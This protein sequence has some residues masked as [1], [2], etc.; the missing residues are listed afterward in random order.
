VLLNILVVL[1][2]RMTTLQ[3]ILMICFYLVVLVAIAYFTRAT[4]RR[5]AGAF[6]SAAAVGLLVLGMV[7]IGEAM[8]LWDVTLSRTP[9]LV[10]MLYLALTVSCAPIYLLSWRIARRFGWAGLAI[11]VGVATIVGPLRDYIVAANHPQWIEFAPGGAPMIA[12]GAIYAVI[13]GVG[14]ALMRLVAGPSRVDSLERYSRMF[15]NAGLCDT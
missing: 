2:N 9:Q 12:V 5:I 15:K 14:H 11:L 1:E 7:A 10:L 6:A 13:V 8:R 4:L 3:L